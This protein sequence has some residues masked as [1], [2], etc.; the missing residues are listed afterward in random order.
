MREV[1]GKT[2]KPY[3]KSRLVVQG[4]GDESKNEI[5]TQAPTIQRMSQRLILVL[6]PSLVKTYEMVGELRDIAQ[7]YPQAHDEPR[8][9]PASLP[10]ELEGRYPK[11]AVLWIKKPLYGLAESGLYWFSKEEMQDFGITALQTDDTLSFGTQ[12]FSHRKEQEM[13]TAGFLTKPKTI[14]SHDHLLEFNGGRIEMDGEDILLIQKGQSENLRTS[15]P[16]AEDA[17]Q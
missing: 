7:A 3:E 11:D 15:D 14:L 8:F 6:G 13:Q 9:I 4:F 17:P 16:R 1:K 10:P 2:I 12:G 5:L